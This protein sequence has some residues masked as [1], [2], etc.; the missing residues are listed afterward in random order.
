MQAIGLTRADDRMSGSFEGALAPVEY[1]YYFVMFYLV[2]G[3]PL[4]LILM[5]GIGSGF[6]LIPVVALCVVALGPSFLT[7]IQAAWIPLACGASYLFIQLALH[8]ESMYAMYVYQFGPWLFSVVVVQALVMHRSNFLHRFAWFT[9]FLGLAMLPFLRYDASI[10][11]GRAALDRDVAYSNPNAMAAWFGF[12]LLYLTI[13][14]YVET[15][16]VYRSAAWL[17]AVGCLYVITLTGSRGALIA[18]AASLLVTSRRLAKVGLLPVLLFAVLLFGL[19][20]SGV[21]DQAISMYTRR[22]AEETGR[23]RVWPLLIEK[24][25][26]SPLIGNG[27]SHAGAVISSGSFVTPH[28][29]FLLFAVAS[30]ALP[31]ILFCAYFFT[32]GMA[33][34]RASVS[35][36]DFLFY[37]PLVAYS[38]LIASSAGNIEFMQPWVIVSLAAP[39]TASVYQMHPDDKKYP[40]THHRG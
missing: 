7:V 5:G 20:E 2:L 18:I 3:A 38:G 32:S 39:V 16:F 37:L 36:Q 12:C 8:G 22:G 15:R 24:F 21:F 4:G 25:I 29:S 11:F 35:D 6:L 10:G 17:M 13:R 9:L 31:F 27:A 14:G 30:G 34:L 23:L 40:R 28:N 26:D 1:G 33:A 19:L